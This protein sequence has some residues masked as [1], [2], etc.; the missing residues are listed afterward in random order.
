MPTLF[1]RHAC[2][3]GGKLSYVWGA[4]WTLRAVSGSS[5]VENS[6][7]SV[8]GPFSVST[9][10]RKYLGSFLS[11]PKNSVCWT[12]VRKFSFLGLIKTFVFGSVSAID[13]KTFSISISQDSAGGILNLSL[14]NK[15]CLSETL[16]EESLCFVLRLWL[17]WM[18]LSFPCTTLAWGRLSGWDFGSTCLS[19]GRKFSDSFVWREQSSFFASLPGCFVCKGQ[20]AACYRQHCLVLKLCN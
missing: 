1:H 13:H 2:W 5:M 14:S 20:T 11:W 4:V 6:F 15:Q 12:S 7:R 16:F 10:C 9:H 8:E 3:G 17:N 19:E 18:F